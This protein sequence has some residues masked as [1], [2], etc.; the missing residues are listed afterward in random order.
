MIEKCKTCPRYDHDNDR[1]RNK[2]WCI[3]S[4][5]DF[6]TD[7]ARKIFEYN[8]AVSG[9]EFDTKELYEHGKKVSGSG[10]KNEIC[11]R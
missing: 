7:Q 8:R 6:Q 5:E 10:W 11:E 9:E 2:L 3:F 4:C 1:Y